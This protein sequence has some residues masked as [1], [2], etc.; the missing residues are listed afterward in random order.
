MTIQ[1]IDVAMEALYETQQKCLQIQKK[2]MIAAMVFFIVGF[3]PLFAN[4]FICIFW[5]N[6]L[7]NRATSLARKKYPYV[8]IGTGYGGRGLSWDPMLTYAAKRLD[9]NLTI[10][11]LRF[12]R[13][14]TRY[15]ICALSGYCLVWVVAGKLLKGIGLDLSVILP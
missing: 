1:E 10:E 12:N 8:P 6:R 9:D 11:I 7:A 14:T 15:V 4:A 5:G 2:L 3:I 13:A